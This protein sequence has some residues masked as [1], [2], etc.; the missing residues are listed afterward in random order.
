MALVFF[1]IVFLKYFCVPDSVVAPLYF[2]AVLDDVFL[3]FFSFVAESALV[4]LLAI[5]VVHLDI[6]HAGSCF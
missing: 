1:H 2:L 3:G 6:H 4:C 5:F